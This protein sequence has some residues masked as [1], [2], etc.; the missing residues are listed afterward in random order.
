MR[1]LIAALI[2]TLF[3]TSNA[4][5][6]TA[7]DPGPFDPNLLIMGW[8]GNNRINP[9]YAAINATDT[10]ISLIVTAQPNNSWIG[11]VSGGAAVPISNTTAI[12]VAI[13]G[14][15]RATLTLGSY[16]KGN[17]T[18]L[19]SLQ[20]A[21]IPATDGGT[22]LITSGT[23]ATKALFSDGANGFVMATPAAPPTVVNFKSDCRVTLTT[24]VPVTTS[25]VTAATTVY[26]TP[27]G[28]N[29]LTIY[30]GSAWVTQSFSEA[31]VAVPATTSQMYSVFVT[32]ASST[33]ITVSATAWTNDTTPGSAALASQDGRQVLSSDHTKLFVG[34][35][36][37]TTVSGQTEDSAA[38]RLVWNMYNQKARRLFAQDTAASWAYALQ[39]WRASDANTTDGQGRVAFITGLVEEPFDVEFVQTVSV[40][41][42]AQR[43]G[44]AGLAMDSTTV[45]EVF[46]QS[47]CAAS[48]G[49]AAAEYLC[50]PVRY[51]K[52][53]TVG[54]HYIQCLEANISNANTI[55]IYGVTTG[56]AANNQN[57][58]MTGWFSM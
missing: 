8:I 51:V 24:A 50:T 7:T 16:L 11:N 19:V 58:W 9:L 18:G 6:A 42:N 30:S 10:Q 17:G 27:Y 34:C 47:G 49:G 53:P 20:A 35:F 14:T 36:R 33:T 44:C 45:P 12:P 39:A 23:D 38:R 25:D 4:F 32:S 48:V 41:E 54:Y 56:A 5:A 40:T 1:R 2:L 37:T 57:S 28:G 21:P 13:G 43:G 55:T 15:G 31:S 3:C 46:T 29:A 22:G 52:I 26:V